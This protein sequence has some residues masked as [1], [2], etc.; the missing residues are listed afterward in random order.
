MKKIYIIVLLLIFCINNSFSQETPN[1]DPIST[2]NLTDTIKNS[3]WKDYW[4]LSGIVGFNVA[5]TQFVH[6]AAGGN[7]NFNGVVFANAT[8]NYKKNKLAW[9]TQLDTEFGY[10]F[11]SELIPTWRKSSDKINFSTKLGFEVADMWFITAMGTFKSQYIP[12]WDFSAPG[13]SPDEEYKKISNWLSPSYTDISLGID[14]KWK[15][16]FTVYVSPLA[17]L[18][19]T[20]T[21]SLLRTSYSVPEDKN[22]SASLGLTIKAGINYTLIKNFKI[23][24]AVQLYTPYTDKEQPF[25]NFNVD[26]DFAIS[27]QFLKVLNVTLTTSLKYYKKTLIANKDGVLAPR[28]QFK[29]VL[30]LG[31]GYSF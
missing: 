5:Q 16:L 22:V 25:G 18:I 7:N 20:C 30:G 11:S 24:T 3:K 21:D 10:M 29:E 14:W 6:W 27:Y 4:K 12:G 15:N 26:W 19:T 31:I 8:L 23:I 13:L 28:V 9:D 17:G 2:E 1:I